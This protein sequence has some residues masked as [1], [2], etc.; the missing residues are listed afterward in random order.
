M[1]P[2]KRRKLMHNSK[3]NGNEK[4]LIQNLNRRNRGIFEKD[5]SA[6]FNPNISRT[7]SPTRSPTPGYYLAIFL[8]Y[9]FYFF[10]LD[11]GLSHGN[12]YQDSRVVMGQF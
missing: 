9:C 1:K 8:F 12:G 7:Q 10:I 3:T 2:K 5:K 11:R 6:I 4:I